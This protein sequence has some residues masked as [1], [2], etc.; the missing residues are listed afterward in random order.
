MAEEKKKKFKRWAEPFFEHP[1]SQNI[2]ESL[3]DDELLEIGRTV[4][5]EFKADVAS[6]SE[7]DNLHASW[8]KLYYQT[9][10]PVNPPWEGSSD[11]SLPLLAESCTQFAARAYQAM[12]PNRTFIKSIPVGKVDPKAIERSKRVSTHLSWQLT[13]KNKTYKRN[14]DRLLLALALHGSFFTK[15][16]YDP[17]KARNVIENVRATDLIVPYGNGPRDIEDLDRK[18]QIIYMSVER[19][20]LLVDQGFFLEE[21]VPEQGDTRTEADK[22]Q[23][24]AHGVE[25]G[26]DVSSR[27]G[28]ILEQ[29]RFL[30]LDDDDLVEP[31][32]VWV[33][34]TNEKVLRITPRYDTDETGQP[35]DNKNPVEYFTHYVYMENPDGFYGLGHGHLIAQI[36]KAVNKLVRQTVDGAT[37]ANVGNS[38]GFI[39]Q[40]LAGVMGGELVMKLGKF[41][42]I[43]GSSDDIAKGIFQFRFPGP[44]QILFNIIQLLLGRSDRLASATEAITGQTENVMQPTTIMALIEQGLQVFSA[45]YARVNDSWASELEKI[46]RLNHKF[47]D[48]NE[49]FAVQ[50]IDGAVKQFEVARDDYAPDL[51]IM[52]IADP[53]MSTKQQVLSKAQAEWGFLSQ[54]PL[55]MNS[56]QHLYNASRRYM[57]AIEADSIDEV[58]PN[59]SQMNPQRIDDPMQ[60][61]MA[62]SQSFPIMGMVFPDQDH[63]A[64][65]QAHFQALDNNEVSSLGRTLLRQH[66]D[67]HKRF[68]N[69]QGGNQGLASGPNNQMGVPASQGAVPGDSLETDILD[70]NP[71]GSQASGPGGSF[72]LP[73]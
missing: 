31:Y 22:A 64:H 25:Q 36:N 68:S 42:K 10:A 11:E 65:I 58:L 30:D 4:C 39:S 63:Q 59:P 18:T 41:V 66:I 70:G 7:W 1:E 6:R 34:A 48:P 33:D 46:A 47:M 26:Q 61:H 21:L 60:E 38:S 16:Y 53:K 44:P 15:T 71:G 40:Q 55:V 67:V 20:R 2:A 49:Y 54:N 27:D 32:I 8:L 3:N 45:V 72:G 73:Q 51:Q 24:E 9:D 62:L 43:P 19:S 35:T 29:H 50:D 52:P 12:F 57:E 23:D 56:P 14:K 13:A 28:K 17:L 69:G 37:L 5:K